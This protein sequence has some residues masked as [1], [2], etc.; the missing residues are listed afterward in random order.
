ML[1][2]CVKGQVGRFGVDADIRAGQGVTAFYGA[3]GAG[4]STLLRAIAGLWTPDEGRIVVGDT[5]LFD[6]SAGI[7]VPVHQ[8]QLGV[9]FQ[10]ALLF[11]TMNVERNLR[12][13]F[14]GGDEALWRTVLDLL[15]LEKLLN[16]AP[17]HLSGGE[18]QRVALGRAL[19][20]QPKILLLDE[21]LTG[22]DEARRRQVIPYLAAIRD[23]MN[24]PIV[25]VS[26]DRHEI[27]ALAD[28][29]FVVENGR[30]I[31]ELEP[32]RFADFDMGISAP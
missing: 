23:S 13:G 20:T 26:H 3:S 15:D 29:I 24:V 28:L 4:K 1:E 2:L 10:A 12:Y 18:A 14:S 31:R 30:V 16:R 5:V 8:R 25:Y 21:P 6:S 9:V 7:N 22:L 32:A 19:L 11:P 17:R 27:A